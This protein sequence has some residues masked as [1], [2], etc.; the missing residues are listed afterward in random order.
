MPPQQ[1]PTS[2]YWLD[3]TL[4]LNITNM[5][6]SNCDFCIRKFKNGVG[7]FRLKL[8]EEPSAAQVIAALK[9]MVHRR[10]WAELVFC[11]FGEP[12]AKLDCL[13]EVTRWIRQNYGKP[14]PIR[15]NT[16]GHGYLLNPDRDVVKELKTAGV[17]KVSVSLNASDEKTYNEVCKPKFEKA[18]AAVL[19]FIGNAKEQLEVEVTAVTIPEVDLHKVE[20]VAEKMGV[21]FRLRQCIPC[22]W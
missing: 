14:L 5:C 16:N 10:R 12:T 22:F 3:D 20:A 21:K 4:Y 17:N 7:G 15:V 11:G 6:S 13:L 1:K 18:Y 8:A 2:V 9:E 19:E